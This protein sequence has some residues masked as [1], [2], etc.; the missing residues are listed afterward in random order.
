MVMTPKEMKM[1]DQMMTARTDSMT[2]R[3]Q[4][5]DGGT[6]G[7]SLQNPVVRAV[8]AIRAAQE[9]LTPSQRAVRDLGR[10][11]TREALATGAFSLSPRG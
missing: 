6:S 2:S 7:F 3:T 1:T 9:D 10:Q 4:N 8:S 11:R 5:F